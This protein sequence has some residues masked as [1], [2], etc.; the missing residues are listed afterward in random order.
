MN[1]NLTAKTAVVTSAS[2]GIGLATVRIPRAG[3]AP[4]AI[5]PL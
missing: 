2:P 1:L 4:G 5:M 3:G